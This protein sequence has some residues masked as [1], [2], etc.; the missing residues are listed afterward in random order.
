MVAYKLD[1]PPES[2]IHSTFHVSLL[3]AALGP[4]TVISPLPGHPKMVVQ[5][6][7]ILDRK[8]VKKNNRV[9]V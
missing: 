9:G 2:Q 1:L 5:P 6:K 7:A 4:A 8:W 3:E